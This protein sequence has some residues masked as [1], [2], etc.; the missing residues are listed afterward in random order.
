MLAFFPNLK[1]LHLWYTSTGNEQIIS[2]PRILE[3]AVHQVPENLLIDCPNLVHLELHATN[4]IN[5][6]W[7]ILNLPKMEKLEYLF[8]SNTNLEFPVVQS[9]SLTVLEM[10]FCGKLQRLFI[11]CTK[12]EKVIMW[13][14]SIDTYE[15]I[16]NG[17]T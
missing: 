17:E 6:N 10:K 12:I 16:Q 11:K 7:L 15:L 4:T 3:I 9:N 5:D 13:R 14:N 8:M 1:K 2:S